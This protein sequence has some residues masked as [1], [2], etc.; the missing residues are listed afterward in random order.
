MALR[1]NSHVYHLFVDPRVQGQGIASALWAEMKAH[2]RAHG[3]PGRFTV[4]S[5]PGAMPVY[6][7]FGFTAAG[8][9][10]EDHGLIYVPMASV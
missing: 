2:A 9:R 3:N 7:A 1:D 4:N 5:S 6:S 10:Q 8:E